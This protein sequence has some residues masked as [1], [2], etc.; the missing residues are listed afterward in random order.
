MSFDAAQFLRNPIRM[1]RA[2]LMMPQVSAD[3]APQVAEK[4]V[5]G[6]MQ[7]TVMADPAAEL[8]DSMEE[9]S[10]Q[11]EEKTTKKLAERK[12]GETRGRPSAY[13]EALEAWMKAMPDM[14]GKEELEKLLRNLR[15]G[16]QAGTPGELKDQLAK[17]SEDPSHQFAMLDVLEQMLGPEEENLRSL[18]SSTRES[19]MAD[20]GEEIRAG[21]NLATEVNARAT[22]PE[23]MS[24]LRNLYRSEILGFT[25]PQDCFRSVLASRGPGSLAAA[26]EFLRAGCGADLACDEP[27][28]DPVALRRI[29][30]DLQCVQVLQ[31]VLDTMS[32]LSARMAKEFGLT[33]RRDA[34][35]MTGTIVSFTEK[36]HVQADELT[37][38]E[39]DC[40]IETLL[41]RMDFARELLGIF[42]KLSSRLFDVED[43]R[44]RLIE[45]AEEHLDGIISEESGEN[46][47][48]DDEED[49]L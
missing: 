43:D 20:R 25:S 33:L 24:D 38:F 37:A 14:P 21:I 23:E 32:G 8:Q 26:I 34:E 15:Q 17:L 7:V 13:I 40:G 10:M 46:E 4:G 49:A 1:D 29:L 45:T 47:E 42:H 36:S 3:L 18:L 30:T 5:L 11:F 31:T 27:S 35:S 19:L 2:D 44:Q 28:R 48:E 41:A 6:G 16:E 22:T 39:Q 9:L 12:L